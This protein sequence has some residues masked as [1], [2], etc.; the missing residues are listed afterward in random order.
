M[1][2]MKTFYG[3]DLCDNGGRTLIADLDGVVKG[4]DI[5]DISANYTWVQGAAQGIYDSSTTSARNQRLIVADS[6][7]IE[8]KCRI[9]VDSTKILYCI[10]L[11]NKYGD[12]LGC[13]KVDGTLDTTAQ[14]QA[15]E[16]T[17]FYRG[18]DYIVPEGK[19]VKIS[20][21]KLDNSQISTD[22]AQYITIHS[23]KSAPMDYLNP[24][25][26][27]N[28]PALDMIGKK[29][30]FLGDSLLEQNSAWA[31]RIAKKYN[32]DYIVR[33]VGQQ[34]W[35]VNS[36]FASGGVYQVKTLIAG[37]FVPDYIVL[38]YGTNDIWVSSG[39]IGQYSDAA[40]DTAQNT[41]SAMRY[42]IETL[43]AT[44]PSAKI[45]VI[46]PCLR[47]NSGKEPTA[48]ATYRTIANQV[49]DDYSIKRIDMYKESGIVFAMMQGDGVHINV[50]V[51]GV[52]IAINK[53][54]ST[55]EKALL[56][57]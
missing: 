31:T 27:F 16:V 20:I 33:G 50:A 3:A 1:A 53:Y 8:G 49:L 36:N 23:S 14:S 19:K 21:K 18:T 48:Q 40:S 30:V 7:Y 10:A 26:A 41:V 25:V 32:M 29:I 12:W 44:Y 45:L 24:V 2:E 57:L 6:G 52:K 51:D 13:V 42:C 4:A 55:V 9:S 11:Y 56:S 46:L 34:R 28:A 47:T 35:W 54:S 15:V 39:T 37:S 22:Y 17:D 43:Q 5:E 38:E